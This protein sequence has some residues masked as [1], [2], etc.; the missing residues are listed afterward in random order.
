MTRPLLAILCLLFVAEITISQPSKND[1]ENPELPS[2]NAESP[3]AYFIPNNSESAA[4][5][6]SP[7]PFIL[8]LNGTWKFKYV[9]NP[10]ARPKDFYKPS[11]DVSE[12]DQIKVPANWQTEGFDTYIFTDVE[13]P[14]PVNPPYVPRDFNPVGSY[15]RSFDVPKDWQKKN[16][17]IHLGAVNSFFYLWINGHY[18]GFSKDSKTPAEFNITPFLKKGSNNV[19][20]QVFRFSDGTYLEGQD[21]W[22]L[23]GIERGI[24]LIARPKFGIRDFFIKA[25]LDG[26]YKNGLLDVAIE[27]DH[28][29][30]P[31]I[32][33]SISLK[34]IDDASG[35]TIYSDNRKT[36]QSTIKFET[37][38]ANVRQWNA[39]TPHLYTLL[40]TQKNAAGKTIES[41]AHKIGFRNVEIK[42]GL[43]LINGNAIKIKGVNRH[44]H[45]MYT[46][47]VITPEEMLE[48]IRVM[49]KFNINAV[50][51]SHYPNAPEWYQLC[52]QYGI[53]V[54]DEANIECDGMSFSTLKTLSDKPEWKAAYLDRTARMFER[55]KNFCSIITWSL[56]NESRFGDNFIATYDFLKMRDNTRPVQYEEAQRT[57]Y[58]D[59]IPPMYKNLG[60]MMEY[61]KEW[62]PKPFIQ[63]EYAHMMGN[64]GGNLK[65]Y[66]DLFYKYDQLQ[67][68][69]IWDFSD[70]AFKIKDKN[71]RDIWGYGRDMG[72]V[73][74]TSDTS[75]PADGLFA[76]DRSPHPQAFELKKVYQYI[77]FETVPLS[78]HAIKITNRYDFTNLSNY[79]ITWNVKADGKIIS[80]GELPAIE[81]EPG[82]STVVAIPFPEIDVQPRT[83]YFLNFEAA[84]KQAKPLL[85]KNFIVATE[86]FRLPYY[87]P[88]PLPTIMGHQPLQKDSTENNFIV[89][90]DKFFASFDLKTGLL[91]GY[92][93]SEKEIIQKALQPYFWRA[94][95]DN[96]IGNSQQIRCAVWQHAFDNAR[97]DSLLI[98]TSNELEWKI[99]SAYFL[100]SVGAQYFISYKV[101]ANGDIKIDVIMHAG[102][103]SIPELPRFGMRVILNPEF[104]KVTWLGRGPFDNYAD[105]KYA[106]N[107]DVYEMPADSLFYPYARA[108][109]SGYR[110]DVRWIGLLNKSG[111]GLMAIG[112]SLISSG[113]V[114]FDYTRLFFDRNATENN[115]G[116]SMNNDNLIWWNIDYRQEGVGGD[117]AWGARPHAEY[118]LP[119]KDYEYSFTLR[120]ISGI[121]HIN[122]NAKY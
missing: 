64:S 121:E 38:I 37:E 14:I 8:S 94:A 26:K 79:L 34:L 111:A 96:D 46:A 50:R 58:T 53:Y 44:E 31:I 117:N 21:M 54:I 91:N 106:A 66:W 7:S 110:T 35:K 51:T 68:G 20:L 97:L 88:T 120:P 122:Q 76:A 90:G 57:P 13:Y 108:Q 48:D 2:Q 116:G 70:Q 78:A 99:K 5:S 24:Y 25:G 114:H 45:N 28:Q 59:I 22:K 42:H 4:L 77:H 17:F 103:S 29:Q 39:E 73:G 85:P 36:G 47:R 74:A 100:P 80:Q 81:L 119:Y 69:F 89:K 63:C 105:R 82:A 71:G 41:I 92:K 86:Q 93:L 10:A 109:E 43:F 18:V 83:E 11:F 30:K 115:H 104:D 67:G 112:D 98:D 61:V 113:V 56:G 65:D 95:T 55:D 52:D 75:F 101:K 102:D 1:W 6:N 60:V 32:N 23:S 16:I 9:K 19:S 40:I 33:E 27:M 12:W 62:R 107:V 15:R 84:P 118:Q 87:D 72:I 49:K 3:H